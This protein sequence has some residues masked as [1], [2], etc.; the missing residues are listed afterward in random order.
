MLHF[1]RR[2]TTLLD[3]SML[4][5]GKPQLQ[6]ESVD[7]AS[8]VRNVVDLVD[9]EANR[10]GSQLT[11]DV[12]DAPIG[13]LDRTRLEQIVLNL[14]SNAIKYG[15]GRPIEVQV[16]EVDAHARITVRDYGVGI[17]PEDQQRIFERFERSRWRAQRHFAGLRRGPVDCPP[18]RRRHAW[19]DQ[20]DECPWGGVIFHCRAAV[21]RD[22]G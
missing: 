16:A 14:M 13:I 7:V 19:H 9:V 1:A 2:A 10:A 15:A 21:S 12:V 20:Y 4:M 5:L 17:A 18:D 22:R 11:V 8:L 6:L 3:V